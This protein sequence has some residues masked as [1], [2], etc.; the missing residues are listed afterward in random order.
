LK[1]ARTVSTEETRAA[2]IERAEALFRLAEEQEHES[3]NIN[4]PPPSAVDDRPVAQQQQQVQPADRAAPMANDD[5]PNAPYKLY[6]G[7]KR[8][9]IYRTRAEARRVQQKLESEAGS[10]RRLFTIKDNLDRIVLWVAGLCY[11]AFTVGQT[12]PWNDHV[13]NTPASP[14]YSKLWRDTPQPRD[15]FGAYTTEQLERMDQEFT[16]AVERAFRAGNESEMAATATYDL[17]RRLG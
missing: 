17:K 16:A 6:D 10:E 2:L 13:R 8:I 3:A 9:G 12:G 14:K 7:D 5:D 15:S 4:S 11:L 1:T